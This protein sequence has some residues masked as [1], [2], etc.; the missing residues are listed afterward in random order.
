MNIGPDA[1]G[2]C[3]HKNFRTTEVVR[4][5]DCE[6]D[7]GTKIAKQEALLEKADA[8]AEAAKKFVEEMEPDYIESDSTAFGLRK[9]LEAYKALRGGGHGL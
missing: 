4:C 8:L 9:T 1:T 3:G 5:L 7:M 2:P 6:W